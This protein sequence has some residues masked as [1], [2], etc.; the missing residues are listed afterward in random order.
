MKIMKIIKMRKIVLLLLLLFGL[1]GNVRVSYADNSGPKSPGTVV[2]D[3]TIGTVA[4]NNPDNAKTANGVFA[5]DSNVPTHYLK[6]TNF[7]FSIPAGAIINGILVE[8]KNRAGFSPLVKDNA[9]RIVKGGSIGSTERKSADWWPETLAYVSYGGPSDLWGETWTA[10]DIN[11][12]TFGFVI[13]A[14]SI[15]SAKTIIY[16][17]HIQITIYY[18]T[19][20]LVVIHSALG[21]Q[22]ILHSYHRLDYADVNAAKAFYEKYIIRI[23]PVEK[24]FTPPEFFTLLGFDMGEKQNDLAVKGDLNNDCKVDL[25]D[26]AIFAGNWF[27]DDRL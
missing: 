19:E 24:T 4:W 7:G 26:F 22:T 14:T 25:I 5:T 18:T 27:V 16:V 6:A 13:S 12:S 2:D 9:I 15:G 1:Y 8:V 20:Y 17:D 11:A 23:G 3:A 10:T 21:T